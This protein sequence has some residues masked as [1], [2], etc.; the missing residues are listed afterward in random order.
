VFI[1]PSGIDTK[2]FKKVKN[3]IRNKYKVKKDEILIGSVG[4]I[5]KIRKLDQFL[6]LFK[7]IVDKNKK[8][9]LMFVGEGDSLQELKDLTKE[10]NLQNN[11]IFTG[12]VPHK[13]I[14]KYMSSF[15]FGLCHLPNIFIYENSVPLKILE[16]L[17]C[18]VPVLA[19]E[20][21]AHNEMS[22]EF[23]SVFIYKTAE[24][25]INIITSMTNTK[26]KGIKEDL[27]YYSWPK[28]GDKYQKIWKD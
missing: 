26:K 12:K 9:K 19:S 23:K 7:E 13:D 15:D 8:I 2:L 24:D 20:I 28:I 5:A 27:R 1:S 22:K 25:I 14:P 3:N 11:V 10:L 16:Y 17:S 6:H 21:K 18:K 4:G